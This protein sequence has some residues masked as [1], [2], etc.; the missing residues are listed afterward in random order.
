MFLYLLILTTQ[1]KS[2]EIHSAVISSFM[3]KFQL[4][5]AEISALRVSN[6]TSREFFEALKRARDIHKDCGLLLQTE[7][8]RAGFV[9]YLHVMLT[10]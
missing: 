4:S 2:N 1:S 9:S 5:E 10:V 6:I 8:Q 7:H 3:A